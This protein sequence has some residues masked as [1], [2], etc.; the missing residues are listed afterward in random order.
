MCAGVTRREVDGVVEAP[1]GLA[2]DRASSISAAVPEALSFAPDPAPRVVTMGDKH[3]R[4]GRAARARPRRDSRRLSRPRPATSASNGSR[5]T[6]KP[7]GRSWS[8]NH[9]A[10]EG[11]A[12]RPR[13][14]VRRRRR[15]V[16]CE[17]RRADPVECR[18]ERR[19]RQRRRPRDG[20]GRQQERERDE[21][22]G[23]AVRA[24]A[25]R[26][27]ERAAPR[28]APPARRWGSRHPGL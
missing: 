19:T 25:D 18:R 15:E 26:P 8:T 6:T 21:E 17:L 23:P 7:Y 13:R 22:P 28:A 10:A 12:G 1:A 5:L 11:R 2:Y 3:D 20:E 9:C 14:P 16:D 27:V 4:R 24:P